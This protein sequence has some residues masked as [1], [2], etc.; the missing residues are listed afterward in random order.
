[1]TDTIADMLTRIRNALMAE[2]RYVDIPFSKMKKQIAHVLKE[3]GMII[4]F[5]ADESGRTLRIFLK[6]NLRN[7]IIH[8]LK[9]ISKPGRRVY[10]GKDAIPYVLDG[11]G[12]AIVS[13]SSGILDGET[14]R[15]QGFGGE[16][17]CSIW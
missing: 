12:F 2:H 1:M 11:L 4:N 13:T 7:P 14:A 8:G 10:V 9:R 6:Y 17:L 15:K 3:K 16:V 5:L